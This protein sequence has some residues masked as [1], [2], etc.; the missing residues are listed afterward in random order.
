MSDAIHS[1]D[2]NRIGDLVDH[3]ISADANPPVVLRSHKFAAA[4]RPRI[5]CK[6]EQCVCHAESRIERESSEVFSAER[7]TT[8]RYIV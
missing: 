5:F 4:N 8:T 1:H 7:S 6:T 3:T 2:S